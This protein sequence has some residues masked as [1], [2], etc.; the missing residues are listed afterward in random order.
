MPPP[1]PPPIIIILE[2]PP[3]IVVVVVPPPPIVV[4]PPPVV[5]V[6]PGTPAGPNFHI[7]LQLPAAGLTPVQ[8]QAVRDA[9]ARW[10]QVIVGDLPADWTVDGLVDDLRIRFNVGVIDGSGG[11]LAKTQLL[12]VRT[13]AIKLP[14]LASI[15]LDSAD[16]AGLSPS[17]LQAVLMHEIGHA[18]GIGDLWASLGLVNNSNAADPRFTGSNAAAEFAA[19][20]GVAQSSVPIDNRTG[21]NATHWREAI[22]G[23]ELMTPLLDANGPYPLSALTLASLKDMGYIVNL[24]AADPYTLPGPGFVFHPNAT[25]PA[26]SGN[27][28]LLDATGGGVTPVQVQAA[29]APDSS[30]HLFFAFDFGPPSSAVEPGFAGVSSTTVYN[31]TRGW[32]WQAGSQVIDKQTGTNPL[33]RLTG[34]FAQTHDATFIVDLPNGTY[35]VIVDMGDDAAAHEGV[36]YSIEGVRRGAISTL[37]GQHTGV[38]HRVEVIDGQMNLHFI[39]TGAPVAL[40]GLE[41][42]QVSTYVT[43]VSSADYTSGTFFLAIENLA[44]GFIL[45]DKVE[46]TSGAALCINGVVLSPNTAYRQYVYQVETNTVG[47]SE[48]V[49]PSSG[50]A[51][52]MPEIPLG[53]RISGDTD[54]DGLENAAEFIIGTRADKADTDGDGISDRAEL[55]QNLDPLGGKSLPNGVIASQTVLGNAVALDVV[56]DPSNAAKLT[57]FVATGS[58]GLAVIDVS[59]YTTPIVLA[60]LDLPGNAQDVAVDSQRQRALVAA[61]DAG[62]LILDVSNLAAPKVLFTIAFDGNVLHVEVRDGLAFVAYGGS[63]A[64]V[65]VN[66][67]EIRQTVNTGSSSTTALAIEGDALYTIGDGSVLRAYSVTGGVLAAGGILALP[68]AGRSLFVGNGVAYIGAESTF[69]GGFMTVN[70]ANVASLSLLSAVDNA[71]IAGRAVALNGSGLGVVVGTPGGVFNNKVLDV[72][73]TGDPANTGDFVA[74]YPLPAAPEAV[75]IA[76]GMA[77]VAAGSAGLVVVNYAGFDGLGI[78]PT[79]SITADAV[80]VDPAKPGIQVI[81][82]RSVRVRPTVTDDVQIRSLELLVN[83]N[84]VG[85]DNNF[86]YELFAQ[87]PVLPGS[88]SSGTMTVQVRATDTGGNVTLSDILSLDVVPDTFPPQLGSINIDEGARRFFV[89]SIDLTFNEPLNSALL[90]TS[91]I[92]LLRDGGDG[93]FGN[94][95]DVAVPVTLDT[96][97]GG[98]ALSIV[99]GGILPA[100]NYRLVVDPSILADRAGNNFAGAIV[101]NFSIRPASDVHAI[102]GVPDI[103]T[104]PSANPGQQIGIAVP[105]DPSTARA[106][107]KVIDASGDVSTRVVNVFRV[108]AAHGIAF[109]NVPIDASSGDAVVYS[110]VGNVRTDFPDGTFPVQILPTITDVQVESV[111]ADGS[112][113]QLLIA[114]TG[115]VEGGGSQYR[116]GSETIS[117]ALTNGGP[118][119]FGRSDVVLGYV[120]N[121]YVRVTVP[122]SAGVFGSISVKTAGGASAA[123]SV[124]VSAIGAVALSGTPADGAQASANAGQSVTLSGVGLNTTTDVLL[125]FVDINGAVQM[126]KLSPS[127]AAADG[128]SATLI[129]PQ[130]ANGAFTVQVFGAAEQRLLQIVPTLTGIDVQDRTVL[131]G[132]GFVEGAGSYSFAGVSVSDSAAVGNDIDVYY[133]Q[134]SQ[135]QNGSAYLNRTALP[136]HGLGNVSVSTA[137]GTSAPL[138]L[139]TVRVSVA[140]TS[141]G[142]VAVDAA[143]KLWVSDQTNPGKLLKIDPGTGQVLQTITMSADFGAPYAFNYAGLQVLGA[144]MTLGGTAVPAGSLLVFNGYPNPDRVVAVDLATGAVIASL[145][146]DA[147]YDLTG[148]T[149][150]A[151]SNRI[152]LAENNGPGNRIVAIN[153]ATG[154]QTGVSTAPFNIQ[155]WSGL[156]ID[157]TTGHLWLGAFNGGGQLVEYQVSGAGVLSELRRLDLASQRVNNNEISGLS[158]AADG[159][160]WVSSTQGEIYKINTA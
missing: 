20:T 4:V 81:E 19:L 156:A 143:G 123:Y 14:S 58:R 136:V 40:N 93:I 56:S 3:P 69:L 30:E 153:A 120:A 18:L 80:D 13:G 25:A 63:L 76:G 66:T 67:G 142:D 122:L 155:S 150:D 129:V 52:D 96:R 28:Q 101:R 71:G 159:S 154:V 89:R 144:A 90:S 24:G 97:S 1:P 110:Q 113:A 132:S 116:F 59:R 99:L 77:Y 37:A 61:G 102:S 48:F 47:V 109:F 51:F 33:A 83:G 57:A 130:Y 55:L 43:P 92:S 72:V 21:A 117:D 38:T 16:L 22:F 46:V 131:F 60:D 23:N 17:Q 157:P 42:H 112:T 160:L 31:A 114:G 146:L 70:V 137:G 8:R 86:P 54:G 108:D 125:R 100:G 98:Q 104:A 36:T 11:T 15:T 119:V 127:T 45:R 106:E 49:T 5:V 73:R 141:L 105:F 124:S 134:A 121:G 111:A 26:N 95:G 88:V 115:F 65:D 44:T 91:G 87:A 39:G 128:S 41:I 133:D 29:P 6:V 158:F 9:A 84:V 32:G 147:N 74:R 94:A 78:A 148:A 7:D 107:F 140:G 145:T 10:E 138:P 2:P 82:G 149:F 68:S 103:P 64:V 79:V 139:N 75:Q 152:F 34:S 118:D 27:G 12:D 85:S 53:N 35:D 135:N 126:V 62:L 151:Q 50:V